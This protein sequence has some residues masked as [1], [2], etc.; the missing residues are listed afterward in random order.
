MFKV[1][2]GDSPD[3]PD[4]MVDEGLDFLERC[5]QHDPN[6]RAS[7]VELLRHDFVKVAEEII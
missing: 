4:N 7:A 6:N 3:P 5:F 1:G 2:M